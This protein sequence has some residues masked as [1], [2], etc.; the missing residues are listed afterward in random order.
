MTRRRRHHYYYVYALRDTPTREIRYVG[1]STDPF[2]RWRDHVFSPLDSLADWIALRGEF[3]EDWPTLI[4]L[5][6]VTP[7]H[8]RS[9]ERHYVQEVGRRG[10]RLLNRTRGG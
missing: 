5:E 3:P 4:I 2:R 1:C 7:D 9:A 6:Q 10:H 8:W